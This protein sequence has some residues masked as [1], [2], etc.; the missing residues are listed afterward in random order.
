[1]K[2]RNRLHGKDQRPLLSPAQ[3]RRERP[4]A[5]LSP[6]RLHGFGAR[7]YRQRQ[8]WCLW[9]VRLDNFTFWL[10]V[11]ERYLP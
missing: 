9:P 1:E 8:N 11:G 5:V 7:H 3:A 6:R 2:V 4:K 10:V